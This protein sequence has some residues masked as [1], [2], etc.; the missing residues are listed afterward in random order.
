MRSA[1]HL[2]RRLLSL[3]PPHAREPA[4]AAAAAARSFAADAAGGGADDAPPP[5]RRGRPPKAK[6]SEEPAAAEVAAA[7]P[8]AAEAAEA[9]KRAPRAP[10]AAAA[11]PP[12]PAAPSAPAAGRG[13]KPRPAEGLATFSARLAPRAEWHSG[14]ALT[15][16]GAPPPAALGAFFDLPAGLVPEADA[17]FYHDPALAGE[18][19]VRQA[20][21]GCKSAAAEFAATGRRALL[22]R[23]ALVELVAAVEGGVAPRLLLEGWTGAGKSAAL[24]TLV[25]WARA[26]G[27]VALYLPSARLAV[28]GGRFVREDSEAEGGA[29]VWH[30]PEAA[31]H[32]LRGVAAAHGEVLKGLRAADGRP[33]A[34]VAAAGLD[35]AT[36][37]KDAVAAALA[38]VHGLLAAP[39]DGPG[40]RTLVAIDDYNALYWRTGYHEPMHAHYRR[41]ISPCELPLAA[42][43]R[44]LAA[45]PAPGAGGVAVVAPSYS[46]GV[47]PALRLPRAPG[48]RA[49]RVPRYALGEVAAA[50][51]ALAAGG[52]IEG[53]P[54]AAALRRALALTNGNARELRQAA[55]GLL[56][57]DSPLGLSLGYKAAAAA[58]LAHALDVQVPA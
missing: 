48:A 53:A 22:L 11:A 12:A 52:A 45:P 4:A 51:A 14:L 8:A 20:D 9:P 6:P 36:T 29:P 1:V 2:A 31:R 16:L 24:L 49:L 54:P 27:W 40:P 21:F 39:A 7:A 32:L 26:S 19:G 5:K 25:A 47:S 57:P 15:A 38:L 56:T 55:A 28:Q 33:L 35:P 34:D 23:P 37:P 43:L 3:Q 13:R 10:M 41:P 50:A 44:V 18:R 58:R 42:G 46:G 30:T 17:A